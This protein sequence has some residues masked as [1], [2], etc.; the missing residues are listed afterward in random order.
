MRDKPL[1]TISVE[2]KVMSLKYLE[3]R[4]YAALKNGHI[5]VYS[6][7]PG[8]YNIVCCKILAGY[9]LGSIRF[10]FVSQTVVIV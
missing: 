1:M 8:A 5:L 9:N 3:G 4:V 7:L 10:H 6:M 2:A